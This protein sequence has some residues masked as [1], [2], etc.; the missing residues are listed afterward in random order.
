MAAREIAAAVQRVESVLRRRPEAGIS[1]DAPAAA[2]WGGGTRVVTRH[3]NGTQVVTD[4][5]IELGGSGDQVSPGWLLRAALASCAV[6]RIAMATA[7]EGIE[8]HSLEARVQS[9]SDARGLLGMAAEDGTPVP[10]GPRDMQLVVRISA[11]GVAA[12]RLHALVQQSCGCSPVGSA[13][14]EAVP[15]ALRIEVEASA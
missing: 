2:R 6:T 1:D 11:P 10:A 3:D 14:E 9:R 12:E 5:P 8:L 4:M 7:S 13:M 15:V